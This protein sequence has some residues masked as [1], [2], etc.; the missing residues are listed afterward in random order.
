MLS[1]VELHSIFSPTQTHRD[2]FILGTD[3]GII[4]LPGNGGL[5]VATW[6]DALQHSRLARRHHHINWSLSEVVSQDWRFKKKRNRDKCNTFYNTTDTV[7][8]KGIG[9][10]SI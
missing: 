9:V 5:G 1:N 10:I 4:P 7:S 2:A 8:I 6:G 3:T